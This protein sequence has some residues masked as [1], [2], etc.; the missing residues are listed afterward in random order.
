ME[1]ITDMPNEIKALLRAKH[2]EK[3]AEIEEKKEL[4]RQAEEEILKEAEKYK[5]SLQNQTEEIDLQ[6]TNKNL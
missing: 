6:K 4:R 1:G 3:R 5:K 2:F